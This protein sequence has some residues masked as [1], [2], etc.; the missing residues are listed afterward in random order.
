MSYPVIQVENL[1]KYYRLGL[2]G[3]GTLREDVNRWV[4]TLRG[5]PDPLLK[6]DEQYQGKRKDGQI[7]ALKNVDLEVNEGEIVGIIG[8]NGAGKSTLLKILS[9]IT[10]PTEGRIKIKGRG[11][12]LLEV[13][14][15]FHPELTGRENIY[16][17]G[18]I[19]GMSS[20]EVTRNL[21]EIIE[22]A[23]I[24]DFIDTPVKRYSSGMTVRLAFAVAAHLEPEILIVDEVLAVG[25]ARF[26][27]KCIGKMSEVA[28]RGRTI[29][30]VSHNMSSISN[31]CNRGVLIEDGSIAFD[32]SVDQCIEKYLNQ[33]ESE[34][35]TG[36][37]MCQK[38]DIAD[39]QKPDI[40]IKSAV[41][42]TQTKHPAY[43]IHYDQE[44]RLIFSYVKKYTAY[45][46][47]IFF[48]IIDSM[49]VTVFTSWSTDALSGFQISDECEGKIEAIIPSR[50]LKPGLY[51]ITF[52]ISKLPSKELIENH[53]LALT[54]EID[55]MGFAMNRDR[56]G[57]VMPQLEWISHS[58]E[59]EE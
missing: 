4:A 29:L 27:K 51:K 8:R 9:K 6:V 53:E 48:R 35:N 44:F 38:S 26:Q 58:R 21:K 34:N 32:G 7:W 37:W 12:S 31:L 15:G 20:A 39:T 33:H 3:G 30:F 18:T 40:E 43:R 46:W 23:G 13:G 19:L 55:E 59:V 36:Q 1:S 25:D 52:G 17:N 50:L 57:V 2:I 54:I 41:I 24:S 11:A 16:L 45:Q 28:S 47:T 10:S 14:T 42:W 49:G 22:F 56:W 5:Q